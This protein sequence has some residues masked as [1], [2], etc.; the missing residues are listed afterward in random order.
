SCDECCRDIPSKNFLEIYH[1][2][3]HY[4]RQC[5]NCQQIFTDS[6]K[7]LKHLRSHLN[8][9]SNQCKICQESYNKKGDWYAHEIEKRICRASSLNDHPSLTRRLTTHAEPP[10]QCSRCGTRFSRP[11]DRNTHSELPPY[12]SVVNIQSI[13]PPYECSRCGAR[14]SRLIDRNTHTQNHNLRCE[15]CKIQMKSRDDLLYHVNEKHQ[16]NEM[17]HVPVVMDPLLEYPNIAITGVYDNSDSMEVLEYPNIAITGVYD[18]SDSMEVLEYPNIAITG[19]YDNSDS[20]EVLEYPNIA[21]TGVYD[22][23]DSMAESSSVDSKSDGMLKSSSLSNESD[24][25]LESSSGDNESDDMLESSSSD[26]KSYTIKESSSS[27]VKSDTIKKSSSL[28][29]NSDSSSIQEAIADIN[30]VYNVK[31]EDK[32]ICFICFKSCP[33]S[34]FL[35]CHM[36][37]HKWFPCPYCPKFFICLHGLEK[38]KNENHYNQGDQG[39]LDQSEKN[40]SLHVRTLYSI[41]RS[42]LIDLFQPLL[43]NQEPY[44]YEKLCRKLKEVEKYLGG[45]SKI[46][47]S[48]LKSPHCMREFCSDMVGEKFI[49]YHFIHYEF[50]HELVFDVHLS[51]SGSNPDQDLFELSDTIWQLKNKMEKLPSYSD[52][53][54]GFLGNIPMFITFVE[55]LKN[56]EPPFEFLVRETLKCFKVMIE[57]ACELPADIAFLS[58]KIIKT[59]VL[60]LLERVNINVALFSYMRAFG[61]GPHN[62]EPWSSEVDDT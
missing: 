49:H 18:N 56:L 38:H 13:D 39:K 60:Y 51:N 3:H 33:T 26:E 17:D 53:G 31:N 57:N 62:C 6:K 34:Q 20:M 25:M 37:A 21:I 47:F 10:Y 35:K 43:G 1:D 7:H 50:P 19:V 23:S 55:K 24:S 2:K 40:L 16:T 36:K 14:F 8:Y 4:I 42:K 28:I 15:L 11:I 5:P 32:F 30:S 59:T 22:N 44:I 48:I 54:I 52:M 45:D 46:N 12:E 58:I 61:N 9:S 27:D 41:I 29:A